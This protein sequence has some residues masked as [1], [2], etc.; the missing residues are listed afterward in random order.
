LHTFGLKEPVDEH[1]SKSLETWRKMSAGVSEKLSGLKSIK[2][3]QKAGK[4]KL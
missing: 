2:V 1:F 4:N 3:K